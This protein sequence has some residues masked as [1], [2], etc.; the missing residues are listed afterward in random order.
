VVNSQN[1]WPAK[2]TTKTFVRASA[3]GFDFWAANSDVATIFSDLIERFDAHVERVEGPVL[4]DWSYANRLVRG[5]SSVVSNHGS[6]TAI[7]LNATRHPRGVSGTF[8][9][10]QVRTIHA[11]LAVYEG[12]VRWGGDYKNAPLDAMHFEINVSKI[13]L[14]PIAQKIKKANMITPDDISKI[15][16]ALRPA[17]RA[18]VID[19]I[20][21]ERL[22]P[23]TVLNAGDPPAKDWT[24]KDWAAASDLK[25]DRA[26]ADLKALLSKE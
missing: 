11:I 23:N 22:I 20:K 19:L 25:A 8:T 24:I 5:S 9:T 17:V 3:C 12:A 16:A 1:G 10:D 21:T 18:E 4:D 26:N 2:A 14:Y 7:D 13:K 6:A 15:V